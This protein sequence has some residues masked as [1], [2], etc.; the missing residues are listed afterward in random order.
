LY[1]AAG[2]EHKYAK[3]LRPGGDSGARACEA[4]AV[5]ESA[6]V[7]SLREWRYHRKLYHQEMPKEF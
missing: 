1:I 2:I 6:D 4:V 5:S 7:S 3:R